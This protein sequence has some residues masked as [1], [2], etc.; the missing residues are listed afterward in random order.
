MKL[1]GC[2]CLRLDEG[3]RAFDIV[4]VVHARGDQAT[5]ASRWEMASVRIHETLSH[6]SGTSRESPTEE[7]IRRLL[8]KTLTISGWRTSNFRPHAMWMRNG[9]KGAALT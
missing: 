9:R 5:G 3:E 7:K 2:N 6:S 4:V 8:L 1:L